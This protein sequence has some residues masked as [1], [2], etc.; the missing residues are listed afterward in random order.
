M[1]VAGSLWGKVTTSDPSTY[2]ENVG[3]IDTQGISGD[4]QL[5]STRHRVVRAGVFFK[6]DASKSRAVIDGSWI[7]VGT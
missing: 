5:S 4:V 1:N 6:W 7:T 2:M 3:K